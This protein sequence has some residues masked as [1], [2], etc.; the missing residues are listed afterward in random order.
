MLRGFKKRGNYPFALGQFG[1][2]WRGEVGGTEVAVKQAR[3]FANDS[4]IKE[5]LRVCC[6][7]PSQNQR[8][9]I[10]FLL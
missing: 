4:D 1:E 9:S 3:I 6:L 2:V 5:V 7:I 8:D 10:T